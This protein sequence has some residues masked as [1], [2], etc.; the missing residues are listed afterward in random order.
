[1]NCQTYRCFLLFFA[2][3]LASNTLLV[4]Q[5][6]GNESATGLL[7]LR[8]GNIVEGV[9]TR[10]GNRLRV[11]LKHG[12]IQLRV[13]QV[14]MFCLTID[15]AYQRRREMRTGSTADSHLD[16]AKWCI[17]HELW[18]YAARE[19]LEARAINPHH[20]RLR[21]VERQLKLANQKKS[22]PP[23]LPIAEK[24]SPLPAE[25][26][27]ALLDQI[28]QKARVTFV[29]S[30]QPMLVKSCATAGCH[31]GQSETE[32]Q[33]NKLAVLGAGHPLA[34]KNNLA[35]VLHHIDFELSGNSP[36]LLSANT[37]HGKST[38]QPLTP[39]K[40]KLLR[41][42]VEQVVAPD[43]PMQDDNI[44]QTAAVGVGA[45]S[46][47]RL[48]ET[49][50]RSLQLAE[51]RNKQNSAQPQQSDPFD[52]EAFNSLYP[53][54]KEESKNSISSTLLPELPQQ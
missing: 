35:A 22:P 47:A 33:L 40:M 16:L 54:K 28:Q 36:L 50:K 24:E 18:E 43:A 21:L 44:V 45:S 17:Q 6:Q 52:P 14:E 30:V 7:V 37:I 31:H 13:E 38:S 2:T 9:V 4:V 11:Q 5:C 32:L 20:P 1:M 34:T 46:V 27:S 25:A 19:T 3:V 12:E 39:H 41:S 29:K 15:E 8:N 48:G 26:N 10:I 51:L 23:K 49:Y 42:W 53:T